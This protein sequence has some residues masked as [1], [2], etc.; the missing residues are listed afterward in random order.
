MSY[1]EHTAI[2]YI[3]IS[4]YLG[5]LSVDSLNLLLDQLHVILELLNL[6]VH[7]FDEAVALLA[8]S[9]KEAQVVLVGVNIL[10]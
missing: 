10:L 5:I 6:A 1:C 7:L 4:A 3:F 9:C 2:F 8:A